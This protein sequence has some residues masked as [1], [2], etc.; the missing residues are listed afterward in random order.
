M[1]G[2]SGSDLLQ[3]Q[4]ISVV[5]FDSDYL[6]AL[7]A[8][9][10]SD[11]SQFTPNLEIRT[12]FAASNP[13][14]FIRGVGLRD[15][16][17]NS[18]SSVAVYNDDIYMNS[19]AGQLAQLFDVENIDVLRGPQGG[20]Y[21][22]NASA[23]AIRVISRKPTGTRSGFA[24]L[25]YGRFNQL[26]VEAAA[27][28]PL[29][30]DVLS[31]RIAGK[32]SLRD[33][34]T[35]NRCA[36]PAFANPVPGGNANTSFA[37]AVHV[38]CF[39]PAALAPRE[40]GG[41]GARIGTPLGVKE[42]VNDINN[43]AMRSI[44]RLELDVGDGLD[45]LV[46]FHG[47]QN[48]GDARQFQVIGAR[49]R[50]RDL[51][52]LIE[53]PLDQF[54]L[55]RYRDPDN[56]FNVGPGKLIRSPFDGDP[57]EGDFNNVEREEIDLFGTNIVAELVTGDWTTK[58]I[59]GYE[60]NQRKTTVNLDGNPF[61][62]LE[63]T[64]ENE[65]WQITGELRTAWDGGQG[66]SFQLAGLFLYEAL[67]VDNNFVLAPLIDER[68]QQYTFF[69][70]H[71]AVFGDT[72]WEI[73]EWLSLQASGRFNYENKEISLLG[74]SES[75]FR[76]D[77]L[78]FT[79]KSEASEFGFAGD[80]TLSYLPTDDVKFYLKYARG[81]K[82]PHING[83]IVAP[84]PAT[85]GGSLTDPVDPE[86]VDSVEMGI[87]S[88][89][90]DSRVR[91]N[92]AVFYY[93]YQDLQ[94]FRLRNAAGGIPV[95]ELINAQD[96][97]ILGIELDVDAR[98]FEGIGPAILDGFHVFASFAWLD[99][100]YTEFLNVNQSVRNLGN[101]S[102]IVNTTIDFSGKQLVNAPEFAFVGF[103]QWILPTDWG[104][105]VPR[106]DWSF[107]DDVFFSP[108]NSELVGQ[109]ALWLMNLRLVY[110][111][112]S[113]NLEISGWVENLTD[114]SYTLDVFNLARF[115]QSIA[116]AIGDPRTYGFTVKVSF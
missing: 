109:S 58:A 31:M 33:G 70:R 6:E 114:Q 8:S 41:G 108:E 113:E 16:N 9:D 10:L 1:I 85:G 87:R 38:A 99:T 116:Y 79:E 49:Q 45:V 68:V 26:D 106:F 86:I 69:T 24:N 105:V 59:V 97:N 112:P 7:G 83:G 72:T 20:I 27:E 62:S 19:P 93:N 60:R 55:N 14:L 30:P 91:L 64:L 71:G 90:W 77:A 107:K 36:D 75:I 3:S 84:T 37:Q 22:R 65:A 98:P 104:T 17:A 29:V 66:L 76:P 39:N 101:T 48:R 44:V 21:G 46:N 50:E 25:T 53:A 12:P 115:R 94:V 2:S 78:T 74:R 4:E 82:G 111:A 80:V 57:F 56:T 88:Q 18:S 81:W 47:G 34:T 89:W 67:K 43:W 73:S 51:E 92:G 110:K 23:G 35:R 15:F 40:F 63:P 96:A 52:P 5:G 95:N 100:K 61:A 103:A 28:S 42:F 13:T 54:D 11:I 102:L 32:M